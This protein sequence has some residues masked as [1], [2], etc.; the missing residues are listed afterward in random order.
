MN[1]IKPGVLCVVVGKHVKPSTRGL[2]V[3]A[4][5]IHERCGDPKCALIDAMWGRQWVC[6]VRSESRLT[7]IAECHL[8]PIAGPAESIEEAKKLSEKI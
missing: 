1:E 2:L 5:R 3:T 4:L 8:R 7:A 6:E